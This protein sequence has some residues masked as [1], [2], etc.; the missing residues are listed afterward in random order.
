MG[1]PLDGLDATA[2]DRARALGATRLVL[3]CRSDDLRA[4]E[5]QLGQAA[6]VRD[7]NV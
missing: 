5:E 6:A 7:A 1:G 4:L 3:S 2:V